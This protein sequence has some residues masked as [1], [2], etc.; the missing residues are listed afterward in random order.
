MKM[1]INVYDK[2]SVLEVN[3]AY[4]S[5]IIPVIV[6]PDAKI[7]EIKDT[8]VFTMISE[9]LLQNNMVRLPAG[10]SSLT[11]S[12]IM[13]EQLDNLAAAKYASKIRVQNFVASREGVAYM[14]DLFEFN[15]TSNILYAEGFFITD[16]NREAKYLEIIKTNN[17][18]LIEALE[19]Y[20]NIKDKIS[21]YYALYSQSKTT[22]D[23]IEKANTVQDIDKYRD[24]FLASF[25]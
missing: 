15:L 16:S 17:V 2:G 4:V 11:P 23:L 6:D 10:V 12:D 5:K 18:K 22:L 1:L 21:E 25:K 8:Q 3:K 13:I 19:K 7:I 24:N 14:Y 9:A 20:L